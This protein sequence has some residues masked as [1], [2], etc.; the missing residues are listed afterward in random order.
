MENFRNRS[1]YIKD[2]RLCTIAKDRVDDTQLDN[3]QGFIEKYSSY[4][5]VIQENLALVSSEKKMLKEWLASPG[6][7]AAL[8]KPYTHSCIVCQDRYCVQIFSSFKVQ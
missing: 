2:E 4:P 5:Y 6:H 7:A 3:H 8:R 1:K